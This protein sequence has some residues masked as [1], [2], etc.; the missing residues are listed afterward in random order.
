MGLFRH[1]Q[2]WYLKR[3]K[4]LPTCLKVI[5]ILETHKPHPL[6]IF[7]RS[8]FLHHSQK[9]NNTLMMAKYSVS[10]EFRVYS[11]SS[12]RNQYNLT[13]DCDISREDCIQ[14]KLTNHWYSLSSI[15]ICQNLWPIGKKAKCVFLYKIK[16]CY[17]NSN[18]VHHL[19]NRL[20]WMPKGLWWWYF[21]PGSG[22]C[23]ELAIYRCSDKV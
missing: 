20:W 6:L 1:P 14:A 12:C 17:S 18:H 4:D 15:V 7:C 2:W 9:V 22:N 11:Y 16:F 5:T 10:C 19:W 23:L 21:H 3:L 8:C 13:L